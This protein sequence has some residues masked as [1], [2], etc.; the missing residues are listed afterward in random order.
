[1]AALAF[2][3]TDL[4]DCHVVR[5]ACTGVLCCENVQI[6]LERAKLHMHSLLSAVRPLVFNR[7]NWL[8]WPSALH[9]FAIAAG[10]HN[11]IVDAFLDAFSKSASLAGQTGSNAHAQEDVVVNVESSAHVPAPHDDHGRDAVREERAKEQRVAVS[12]MQGKVLQSVLL[13]KLPLVPQQRLMH[14]M[15]HTISASWDAE[16]TRS[17]AQVQQR[18]Y[19]PLL[20]HQGAELDKY[21]REVMQTLLDQ[22]YWRQFA[23]TEEFRSLLLRHCMRCA[24]VTHQLIQVKVSQCPYRMYKLL[25]RDEHLLERATEILALPPCC[26]DHFA[27]HMCKTY[28]TAHELAGKEASSLLRQVATAAMCTTYTT[29]RLHAKNL[30]RVKS[31]AMTQVLHVKDLGLPHIGLAGPTYLHTPIGDDVA[32]RSRGRPKRKKEDEEQEEPEKRRRGGGGSWRCFQHMRH[33]SKKFDAAS[34]KQLSVEYHGLSA[35]ELRVYEE[36]GRA[37]FVAGWR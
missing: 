13:L 10:C 4:R 2:F 15:V 28:K 8:Q 25:V 31:R 33:G 9:F 26:L 3:N 20:L 27:A 23:E 19:R 16:Q 34:M 5:H 11:V 17:H 32:H 29:E 24:A 1:M 37:G 36:A 7:S 30:R 14:F 6:S 12:F 35:D 22:R 21:F 18:M